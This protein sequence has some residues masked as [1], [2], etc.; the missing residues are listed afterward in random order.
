MKTALNEIK[1]I[2]KDLSSHGADFDWLL[3]IINDQI[4]T[5]KQQI[6]E[7]YEKDICGNENFTYS[8]GLQYYNETF[9]NQ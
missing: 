4:E 5:E 1:K 3:K 7:A 2:V 6:I 9:N 8:T